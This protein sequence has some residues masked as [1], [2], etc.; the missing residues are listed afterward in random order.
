MHPLSTLVCMGC[1]AKESA[2]VALASTVYPH[3]WVVHTLVNRETGKTGQLVVCPAC[4]PALRQVLAA[5]QAGPAEPGGG[6]E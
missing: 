4:R 3:G 1:A 2:M 5:R 6:A